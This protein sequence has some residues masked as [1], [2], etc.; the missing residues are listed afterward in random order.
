MLSVKEARD[1]ILTAITPTPAEQI[2]MANGLGRVLAED[3]A[4]RRTQ[5]PTDVSAMDG[6]AV[7]AADVATV[8]TTLK[9]IGHAPAGGEH[10]GALDAGETVRIFTGGPVP[11]GAD[12]IVI[13]E[14]T[15]A[16][17]DA[18]TVKESSPVGHYVRPAGLDFSEGDVILRA[19]DVM[20]ARNV[21]IAAAMNVPWLSVRR[22]P[23]IAILA[24]GDEIVMPG[25][26]LGPNQIVSSNSL[27]LA[28]TIEAVG[29]EPILL[30]IAPDDRDALSAMA[31]AA[32]GADMLV[33]TG[34]A[35]VGDHDLIQSVLGDDGLEVDFW[36]IAMRPGK[37]LI[38]GHIKGTPLLGL[39]G[40]PVSTLVCG[41]I[42]LIPAL[43]KM[44]GCAPVTNAT[45]SVVL[46]VDL[47]ANDQ[48]EDYLRARLSVD[49]K[50]L[51]VATPFSKQDSSMLSRLVLADCLIIRA[52]HAAAINAGAQVD[53][54]P[55]PHGLTRI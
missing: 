2:G 38:F 31:A 30:G 36:R 11:K 9:I 15:D 8:P 41:I 7:R 42:F 21:G 35:S 49:E 26:P 29:G 16:D 3:I 27:A 25:D 10:D 39:P 17:G 47:G 46:G 50:G 32:S 20:T 40:N 19:G 23:R 12:A 6:Y 33:T 48:R 34:G 55:M 5:P 28:A 54:L 1:R 18:V 14:D 24:T 52:P 43:Q 13:Q 53:I 51:R 45:E 44:L 22:K 4:S 37:P